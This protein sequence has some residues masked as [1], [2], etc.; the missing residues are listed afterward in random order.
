[1]N[2]SGK[3]LADLLNFFSFSFQKNDVLFLLQDDSDQ[4]E[5]GVKLVQGGGTAG[6][7][8][9]ESVYQNVKKFGFLPENIWRL[10]IGIRPEQNRLKSETFVLSN[11]SEI[12]EKTIQNL[13][14]K[15]LVTT[16]KLLQKDFAGMQNI[17]NTKG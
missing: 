5:G 6:H 16:P 2:E 17:L 9:V 7:R 10:K 8:G 11:L 13:A 3:P 15:M 1:M 4:L 12:D 14:N